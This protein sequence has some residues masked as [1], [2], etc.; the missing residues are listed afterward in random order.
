MVKR[1][2][3]LPNPFYILLLIVSTLF[4][5]TALGYLVGPMIEQRARQ[6]AKGPPSPASRALAD[7]LERRGPLALGIEF[8]V[9]LGSGILAMSTDHWFSPGP[10]RKGQGP[11]AP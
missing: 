4:V 9:M 2:R 5:I 3:K 8:L 11:L 10:S 7:W 1:P 6:Q